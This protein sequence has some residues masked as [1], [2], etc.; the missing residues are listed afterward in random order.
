[1]TRAIDVVR[2]VAPNARPEYVQAFERGDP[3]LRQHDITTPKRLTH[4]L[5]QCLHES[6]GLVIQ[7]ES[8]NYS[9]ER[10]VE[11]FGV[12]RH[13]A[14][15]TPDEA[16][17]LARNASKI[18]ERVYGLGN[19]S[20]ARELGNTR[21]GDGFRYRGGG[22]MQTTGR[23]NYR[24]MGEK[25][26]VDFEGKPELIV[27]AE[28]ALKPALAEWSAQGLNAF[29]DNDD[30][31]SISRAINLGG[32]Y[33]KGR[34]NGIE[35]R[36]RW[37]AKVQPWV[38]RVDF[39]GATGAPDPVRPSPT[40]PPLGPSTP[41]VLVAPLIGTNLYRMGNQGPVVRAFQLALARLGYGLRGTGYYGGA[42]ET[43]VTDFQQR[44]GIEVDG[45]V[46]PE[47][48]AAIDR[49][50]AALPPAA[51]RPADGPLPAGTA[52]DG[53]PIWLIEGLRWLG[54]TETPGSADNP[55]ILEWAR[56]ERGDISRVFTHDSIPWCALFANMVLTKVGIKGTETLWAL[57]W[58]TWG[59]KLPGPA[60]GAFAP[61]E[62]R[63]Q[64]GNKAGHIAIVVGCDQH[65]N[66]MCLG[67]N[68]D[69]AVNIKPFPAAR[70]LSFRW[71][72][73]VSAPAL[74]GFGNLPLVRSDG[75]VSAR[76]G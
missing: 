59:Q 30:L 5:A 62:R 7:W 21:P 58:A 50:V 38:T 52:T 36:A 29:A 51:P 31:Q 20:K 69:D 8:G 75:R 45:V 40:L 53:R 35:D 46:G 11:I 42:T 74:T 3:L 49:A 1:M 73:E 65:G 48:A 12:G 32:P 22:L 26:G 41:Q 61:M 16:Q 19:E 56:D 64:N 33:R 15:V 23:S 60:V 57:D 4:F 39:D 9:A 70:P 27:S 44:S 37:L 72:V 18:F 13:S 55:Q 71:P 63:D 47:T 76:E 10:L 43:S 28:H 14:G 67:G 2:K 66:L 54:T 34:V 17:A 68:Q 24:S 6:G 25:C